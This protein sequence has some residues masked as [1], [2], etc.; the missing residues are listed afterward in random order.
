MQT[1]HFQHYYSALDNVSFSVGE[2]RRD[3]TL[4]AQETVGAFLLTVTIML[5][6]GIFMLDEGSRRNNG[7]LIHFAN[8]CQSHSVS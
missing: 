4:S 5:V 8:L 6:R 1:V 2:T 7:K 3:G